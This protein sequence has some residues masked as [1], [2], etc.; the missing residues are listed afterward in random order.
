MITSS[1]DQYP[2]ISTLELQS[3]LEYIPSSLQCLLQHLFVG[4]DT[5][6]KVA[7][8]GQSIVHAM[9]P[10]ALIVPLQIGLAVQVHLHVRSRFLVDSLSAMGFFF[11]SYSEV[12]RF[13]EN[14][15][16][17]TA[18][19]LLGDGDTE[20]PDST[21][22]FADD[23]VDHIMTLDGKGT[24]H[25]MGM[26]AAITPRRQVCQTIPRS[27]IKDLKIAAELTEVDVKEYQFTKYAHDNIK[28]DPL[29][30][31]EA[32]DQKIDLLWEMSLSFKQPTPNW[33]GMMHLLHKDCS[34]LGQSS[35]VFLPIIDMYSGDKS[36]IFS[37][38][39]YLCKIADD[40]ESPAVVTFD[41]PLYWKASQIKHELPANS[42][43]RD[44]VVAAGKLPHTN[45]SSG[46]N[47]NIDGRKWNQ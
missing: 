12:Q 17:Y 28:F 39:Q 10:R 47:R 45:E 15:A 27:R 44:V 22:M 40:H 9:R 37:T 32:A 16:T 11:S 42:P 43:V 19:D 1:I 18:L 25:G 34:H 4:K 7:S 20:G 3:A 38:L 41:Q 26:I 24:F 8:I 36:C 35:V 2:D 46:C 23:N 14:A 6:R 29:P 5:C 33:N 13:E 30:F 21:L 31:L